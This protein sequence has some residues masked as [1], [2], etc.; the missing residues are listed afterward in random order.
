MGLVSFASIACI[1]TVLHLLTHIV[2]NLV[3]EKIFI[4]RLPILILQSGMATCAS[5]LLRLIE[6]FVLVSLFI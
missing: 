3:E 4:I 5:S 2:V 6:V 1:F